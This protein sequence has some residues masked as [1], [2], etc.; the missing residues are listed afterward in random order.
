VAEQARKDHLA[1]IGPGEDLET[2][3]RSNVWTPRY[4]P[5]RL[6]K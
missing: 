1:L 5:Y 3:V 6:A 4:V 2:A